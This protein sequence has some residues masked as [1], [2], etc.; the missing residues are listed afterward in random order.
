MTDAIGK[1]VMLEP[2]DHPGKQVVHQGE[3]HSLIIGGFSYGGPS[4]VFI[5]VPALDGRNETISLE[6]KS[7]NGCFVHSGMSS[8]RGV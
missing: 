4:S 7:Q 2:I 6:S 8:G 3:E 5:V 1:L